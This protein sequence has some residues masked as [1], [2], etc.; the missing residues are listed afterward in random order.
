MHKVVVLDSN[1]TKRRN[2]KYLE[3]LSNKSDLFEV[4]SVAS[5]KDAIA[6]LENERI[7]VLLINHLDSLSIDGLEILAHVT[8]NHPTL[9]CIIMTSYGKPWFNDFEKKRAVYIL[10]KPIDEGS[11][12]TS[13]LVAL[14]MRDQNM[15]P[16]CM[17]VTSILPLIQMEQRTCGLTVEKRNREKGFLYFEKGELIGA[18][19]KNNNGENAAHEIAGWNQVKLGIG[20]LRRRKRYRHFNIDLMDLAGAE[21]FHDGGKVAPAAITAPDASTRL[22]DMAEKELEY[23]FF[24]DAMD[25]TAHSFKQS[26]ADD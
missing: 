9:P 18:F 3:M 26:P 20:K 10:N 14:D 5:T 22:P 1:Q 13:V 16:E 11:L 7:S 6:T 23:C 2:R 19:C 15:V 21:W 17:T 8:R 24:G 25:T 4:I 12:I